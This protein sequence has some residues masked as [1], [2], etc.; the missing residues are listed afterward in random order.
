MENQ[1]DNFKYVENEVLLS[2][3]NQCNGLKYY[4]LKFEKFVSTDLVT[5]GDQDLD[6]ND[7]EEVRFKERLNG[8]KKDVLSVRVNEFVMQDFKREMNKINLILQKLD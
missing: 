8:G 7:E 3:G 1:V 2:S 6:K 5:L 4:D